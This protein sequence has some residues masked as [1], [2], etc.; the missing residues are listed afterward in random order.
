MDRGARLEWADLFAALAL[1]G[2]LG[3]CYMFVT[4]THT[5]GEPQNHAMSKPKP[6]ARAAY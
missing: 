4:Q 2:L 1:V 5:A 3:G 6:L